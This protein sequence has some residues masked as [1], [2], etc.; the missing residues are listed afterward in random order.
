[1]ALFQYLTEVGFP[2]ALVQTLMETQFQMSFLFS[3]FRIWSYDFLFLGTS[4]FLS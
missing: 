3:C 2:K 4:K 1:M